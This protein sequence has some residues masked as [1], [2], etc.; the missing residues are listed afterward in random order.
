MSIEITAPTASPVKTTSK[1]KQVKSKKKL[2]SSVRPKAAEGL[3]TTAITP[4]EYGG[5]QTAFNHFNR[6]L[7]DNSLPDLFIVYSRR[8]R[9]GGHYAPK[10]YS[11]RN[12]SFSRDELSL[13]SD[14]F[15]QR[16]DE[17]ICSVLTHEMVHH[18]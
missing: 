6:V 5:L 16:D 8:A 18:W 15:V 9:S 3:D 10:R 4:I 14:S 7:F 1:P 17:W 2:H 11:G 13:N 12:D